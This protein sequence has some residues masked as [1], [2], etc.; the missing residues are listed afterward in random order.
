MNQRPIS[1]EEVVKIVKKCKKV[2]SEYICTI[3]TEIM[4]DP[5]VDAVGT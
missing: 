4:I 1:T 5:V 2:P 3:T